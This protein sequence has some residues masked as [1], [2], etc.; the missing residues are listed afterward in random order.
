MICLIYVHLTFIYF[1]KNVQ[2]IMHV[3]MGYLRCQILTVTTASFAIDF[4]DLMIMP[5]IRFDGFAFIF[6]YSLSDRP[7]RTVLTP[8]KYQ[9]FVNFII[10]QLT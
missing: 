7:P 9:H 6:D 4:L 8:L 2:I 3:F 1:L 5:T 10:E